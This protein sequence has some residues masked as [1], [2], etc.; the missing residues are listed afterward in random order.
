MARKRSDSTTHAVETM[1]AVLAGPVQPPAHITLTETEQPF[2]EAIVSARA[3]N[4][5]NVADLTLAANL[6]RCQAS[7]ERL[8]AEVVK[9][10]DILTN[11]KGTSVVNPKHSLLETLSRRAVALSRV[12][13]VHAEATV[14]RSRD[15]GN[16]LV[17]QKGAEAAVGAV[18]QSEEHSLLPGLNTLQ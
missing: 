8:Q 13:H 14:G 6:A 10:G 15:G 7:I 2:W 1:Q 5:W 17:T 4:T 9:E 11:A 18:S 16:K 12:V 3:A